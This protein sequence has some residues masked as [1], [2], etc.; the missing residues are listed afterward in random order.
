M[1]LLGFK[2]DEKDWKSFILA[3]PHQ[4]LH[5]LTKARTKLLPLRASHY[6]RV[7]TTF[8]GEEKVII[9]HRHIIHIWDY[10][11]LPAISKHFVSSCLT[12][13][14]NTD[15]TQKLFSININIKTSLTHALRFKQASQ[16]FNKG[17]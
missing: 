8:L 1:N 4:N 14:L 3:L 15:I 11:A 16:H 6:K 10:T 7:V 9:S 12:I 2:H 5:K 17:D 13:L